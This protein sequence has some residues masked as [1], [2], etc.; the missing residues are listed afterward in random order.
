M[1]TA[2]QY[3]I[4]KKALVEQRKKVTA[5]PEAANKFLSELGLDKVVMAPPKVTPSK[6]TVVNKSSKKK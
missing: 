3:K 4:L 2:A 5:S 6:K 1:M